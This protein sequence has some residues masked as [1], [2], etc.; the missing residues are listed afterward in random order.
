MAAHLQVS[1][2]T[3]PTVSSRVNEFS[4][5]LVFIAVSAA[6]S[7]NHRKI[8]SANLGSC[9]VLSAGSDSAKIAWIRILP[10]RRRNFHQLNFIDDYKIF[11]TPNRRTLGD[12]YIKLRGSDI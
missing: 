1:N 6:V 12:W 7:P 2:E 11:F 9:T 10:L 3:D 4:R 5:F 8:A